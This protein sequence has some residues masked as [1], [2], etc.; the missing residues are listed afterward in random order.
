MSR[1]ERGKDHDR[2]QGTAGRCAAKLGRNTMN[3]FIIK[4]ER[5]ETGGKKEACWHTRTTLQ[6]LRRMGSLACIWQSLQTANSEGL[7]IIAIFRWQSSTMAREPQ[8]FIN[9]V[10][11]LKLENVKTTRLTSLDRSR[12]SCITIIYSHKSTIALQIHSCTNIT[13]QT[14]QRKISS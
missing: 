3:A 9:V 12:K 7:A 1:R 14:K 10:I 11:F 13:D 8:I 6:Q 4:A 5:G 2:L